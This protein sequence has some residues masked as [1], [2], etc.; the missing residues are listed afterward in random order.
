MGKEDNTHYPWLVSQLVFHVSSCYIDDAFREDD[1]EEDGEHCGQ[2]QRIMICCVPFW[3]SWQC[4]RD[5]ALPRLIG[6]GAWSSIIGRW[7]LGL[8]ILF[9]YELC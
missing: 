6:H 9:Y 8:Q 7:M 4:V 1:K 3:L 5:L 2:F